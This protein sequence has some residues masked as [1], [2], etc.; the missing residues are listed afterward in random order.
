MFLEIQRSFNM[1]QP[2]FVIALFCWPLRSASHFVGP[3]PVDEL[4]DGFKIELSE[5]LVIQL[6]TNAS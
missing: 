1:E 5:R 2:I 4:E 3:F 6:T